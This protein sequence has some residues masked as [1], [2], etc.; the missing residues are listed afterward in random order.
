[1]LVGEFTVAIVN[2]TLLIKIG[3][4]GFALVNWSPLTQVTAIAL[5]FTVPVSCHF[6][7]E[8]PLIPPV[9]AAKT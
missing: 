8:P 3:S 2:L 7:T 1:M 6:G 9:V 4:A 5:V